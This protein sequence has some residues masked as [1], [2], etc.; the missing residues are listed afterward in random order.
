MKAV[1]DPTT[2]DFDQLLAFQSTLCAPDFKPVLAWGGGRQPD[3]SI[4]LP[5]PEYHPAVDEF[6]RAASAE[7]W[8]DYE[9]V[10][11]IRS[12]RPG[13]AKLISGASL[14]QLRT[15]LT[16]IVRGERFSDG[17]WGAMIKEGIVCAVLVRLADVSTKT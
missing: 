9:Y 1:P 8:R 14:N 5:Y 17:H 7:C 15:V 3:G 13:M 10:E 12:L 6:I 11:N 16:Y 4:Q 2:E